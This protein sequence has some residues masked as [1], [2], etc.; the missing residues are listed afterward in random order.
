MP[1]ILQQKGAI[2]NIGVSGIQ[3]VLADVHSTAYTSAKLALWAVTKAFAKEFASKGI[4][5]NM[6]SPGVLEKTVDA[7]ALPMGRR[8]TF[9]ETARV[10]VFLLAEEKSYITGQKIEVAGGVRL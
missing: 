5:V 4:R 2:V 1:S 9:A 3:H 7:P 8:A 6:V 10:V